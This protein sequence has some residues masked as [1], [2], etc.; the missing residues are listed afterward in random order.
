MECIKFRKIGL[1]NKKGQAPR[2]S[3]YSRLIQ[4]ETLDELWSN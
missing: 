2:Y 1:S 4:A 3:S